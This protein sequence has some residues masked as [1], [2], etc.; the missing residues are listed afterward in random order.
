MRTVD[1]RQRIDARIALAVSGVVGVIAFAAGTLLATD[2]P[3]EYGTGPATVSTPIDLRAIEQSIADLQRTLA[4]REDMLAP[5]TPT[6]GREVTG[7]GLAV[8]LERLDHIEALLAERS[9]GATAV[10][11]RPGWRAIETDLRSLRRPTDIAE[12]RRFID[13]HKDDI[14]HSRVPFV[15]SLMGV[16]EVIDRFGWP[17]QIEMRT[18]SGSYELTYRIHPATGTSQ[19]TFQIVCTVL[20]TTTTYAYFED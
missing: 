5:V 6:G 4:T 8:V 15:L 14:E 17:E 19:G 16:R 12:I 18:S 20:G 3:R 1:D 13:E 10:G 9:S 2:G 11:P 7:G